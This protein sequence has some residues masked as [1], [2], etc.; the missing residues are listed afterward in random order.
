MLSCRNYGFCDVVLP[1]VAQNVI[2]LFI[3]ASFVLYRRQI[4]K[5]PRRIGEPTQL[6]ADSDMRVAW[7]LISP[8]KSLFKALPSMKKP[9]IAIRKKWSNE[10]S[11]HLSNYLYDP[12]LF[13]ARHTNETFSLDNFTT[14]DF[15]GIFS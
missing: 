7:A 8:D 3:V 13:V 1:L 6:M 4:L 15:L 5:F 14:F 9:C 2:P 11:V 12:L 10:P